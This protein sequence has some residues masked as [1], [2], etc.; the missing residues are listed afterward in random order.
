V[1]ETLAGHLVRDPHDL[2]A[3]TR[4]Q[5]RQAVAEVQRRVGDQYGESAV[6]NAVKDAYA[7][8]GDQAKVES[9]LPILVARAAEK[10]LVEQG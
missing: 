2:H 10:K 6:Q 9:F 8:I 5:L 7:E 1:S 4:D 3:E